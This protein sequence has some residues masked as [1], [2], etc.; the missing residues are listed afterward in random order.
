[1]LL[2]RLVVVFLFVVPFGLTVAQPASESR[3][4]T[5][6]VEGTT[7]FADIVRVV[8]N[9]RAGTPV[10][11]IDLEAERNRVYALGSFASVS[12]NLQTRGGQ[13]MLVVTVQEN[14]LI[15]DLRF[16]GVTIVDPELLAGVVEAENILSPGR[17]LNTARAQEGIRT[18]QAIYRQQGYPFTVPV[19]LELLSTVGEDGE[20]EVIIEYVVDENLAVEEVVVTGA[21]V[22]DQAAIEGFFNPLVVTGEF[23]LGLYRTAVMSVENHYADMG[24]R[25][26]GVDLTTVS[27]EAGILNIPVV[28]RRITAVDTSAVQLEAS[29][30]S[31][32][33]GDLFNYDTLLDDVRRISSGAS[34]DIR[35]VTQAIGAGGVR[36]TFEVGPPETAGVITETVIEGNTVIPADEI[37]EV[38]ELRP[39]DTF[40][41]TLAE[42]DFRR[43]LELYESE[44]Y[45]IISTPDFNW[46]EGTY[47]HRIHEVTVAGY[48]VTF[49]GERGR[50]QDFVITRYL[51]PIGNVVNQ[52][53]LRVSLMQMQALGAVEP[54]NVHL[55]A[56]DEPDEVIVNAIVR[57]AS[58][59]V[60]TPSAQ[61][62]TDTGFSL[63][64]SYTESNL[65]GRAHNAGIEVGAQTSQIGLL[66]SGSIRYSIP[67]LYL[68]FLD[69]QEVPTGL[70]VAV[71]SLATTNQVM[72]AGT[73]FRVPYP[74]RPATESNLVNVGEYTSR[75]S[76]F[77]ISINRPV[78]TDTVLGLNSR[79]VYTSYIQEPGVQCTFD[80]S[81][82]IENGDRCSLPWDEASQYL[83]QGGTSSFHSATL[84]YDSRDSAEFPRRGLRLNA[85]L[86][87]GF[88]NDFRHPDTGL[89]AGYRYQQLELGARAYLQMN[90]VFSGMNDNH[91]LAFRVNFGHQFGGHYPLNRRF[92]VGKTN[93][94][95]AAIRGYQAADFGL[96]RTYLTSSLEY[97]YDFGLDTFAT[98]TVIG[99]LFADLGYASSATGFAEYAAPVFAGAGLGVQVNLGFG[100]VLLPA[101]RFDYAFSERHPSGEFRFRVGTVF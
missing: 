80:D 95:A 68:D 22:G 32:G 26:S 19:T 28:E 44:G 56:T 87:F 73:E 69:L 42:E 61:Y 1:M 15:S 81:G 8:L 13:P 76:G 7:G 14:P 72:T 47:V 48:E 59:G 38:L 16:E 90:R 89:Q 83:P 25:L 18:V 23:D 45:I 75:E 41:S 67:W 54:V 33:V 65:W 86:G 94:E 93:N 77:S 3:V 71:F 9:A 53:D 40:T 64:L 60:F 101:L 91:V 50:T 84:V 79:V 10:A 97:R 46:I 21:G 96:S 88:G 5:V 39:G 29:D 37:Y 24:Y 98:Q 30:L 74:G 55:L 20:Q 43:I 49:E 70:S 78:F 11:D 27:L 62:S 66:F 58:T 57:K 82:A 6:V 4:S 12:V 100:G 2:K 31:L 34:S 92:T 35:L 99:I 52:N 17:V 36:V 51:P 85:L 63:S